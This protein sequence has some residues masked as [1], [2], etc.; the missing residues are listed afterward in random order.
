[1]L[2]SPNRVWVLNSTG[3]AVTDLVLDLSVD[4]DDWRMTMKA[5][6]LEPGD[7]LL[8]R[9][10]RNDFASV[11]RFRLAGEQYEHRHAAIDLWTGDGWRFEI[12]SGGA[13]RSGYDAAKS[14]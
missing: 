5:E 9:H 4:A 3:V 1:M 11:L 12:M 13:V 14:D 8:M 6:S 10:G 2:A 7:S